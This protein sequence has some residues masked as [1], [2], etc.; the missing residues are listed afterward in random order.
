MKHRIKSR[1]SETY[2]VGWQVPNVA[3]VVE[4]L[5]IVLLVA[6]LVSEAISIEHSIGVDWLSIVKHGLLTV[7]VGAEEVIIYSLVWIDV[8][9]AVVLASIPHHLATHILVIVHLAHVVHVVVVLVHFGVVILVIV[10]GV[11]SVHFQI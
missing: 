6:F 7:V 5:V 4:V 1:K 9:L 10:V 2:M 8:V 3:G 11:L